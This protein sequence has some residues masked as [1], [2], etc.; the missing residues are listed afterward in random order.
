MHKPAPRAARRPDFKSGAELVEYSFHDALFR[1]SFFF[2][3]HGGIVSKSLF[4]YL[5]GIVLVTLLAATAT[6]LPG[7]ATSSL[8]LGA[9]G[10][11]W[12]NTYETG[13]GDITLLNLTSFLLSLLVSNVTSRWWQTRLLVQDASNAAVQLFFSLHGALEPLPP[14]SPAAAPRARI[15]A[16]I[17]RRLRLSFRIML[18]AASTDETESCSAKVDAMLDKL[19]RPSACACAAPPP[20]SPA[21]PSCAGCGRARRG[22]LLLRSELALLQRHRHAYLVL[23]WLQRDLAALGKGGHLERGL[24]ECQALVGRLRALAEDVP[25]HVR[26]QL[27][28]VTVSL[29]ACVV[30]LTILQIMY[31]SASYIGAGLGNAALRPKAVVGLFC[32]CVVPGVFLCILKMQ[33]LLSNPFGKVRARGPRELVVGSRPPPHTHISPRP[34]YARPSHTMATTRCRPDSPSPAHARPHTR[35]PRHARLTRSSTRRA[36]T[37]PSRS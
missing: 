33:A 37:S 31:A 14:A 29:V 23:G 24:G 35:A 2:F 25:M 5:L 19:T 27:P 10:G 7:S 28:F 20:F 15:L 8:L 6:C 30:H 16:S 36:P 34:A 18:I 26:V 17:K 3:W 32:I 22:A 9:D 11:C 13:W 1:D 12:L 21:E 4:I